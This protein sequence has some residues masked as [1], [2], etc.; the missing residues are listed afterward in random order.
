MSWRNT[1]V[2]LAVAVLLGAGI[3]LSNRRESEQQEAE[4]QAK[5]LFGAL[6]AGQVEW[7]ALTT[8]DGREARLARQEGAWRMTGP[9]DFPAD[10]TA[11][12]AIAGALARLTSE[13][14]I[15]DPEPPAVYGLGEGVRIVRFAAKGQEHELRLGKKTPVGSSHYAATGAGEG[16]PVYTVAAFATT[17]FDKALDDLRERRPLR[18]ER[19]AVTRIEADWTGGRAVVEKQDGRW[20]LVEPFAGEADEDTIETLLSDLAFLRAAGFVDEPPPPAE[21]G[22]DAPEYRVV[23]IGTAAEGKPAPRWELAIGSVIEPN[24]R[25]GKAAEPALYKIPVDRFEKLPKKVEAFRFKQL[26]QFVASD[27]ERFELIFPDLAAARQGASEVVTITGTRTDEGWE[28]TPE[29]MAAGLAARMVAELSRLDAAGIAADEV[30]PQE[31]AGLGLSP[32][33]ATIRVYGK[34]EVPE[35]TAGADEGAAALLADLQ[36]GV[37]DGDRIIA[38][39]ADRPTIFRLDAAKAED[40]PVSLEAFR[41]RFVS[42]EAPAEETESPPGVP[43]A[44]APAAGAA[45]PAEA[46]APAEGAAPPGGP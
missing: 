4:E 1:L 15:E 41:N 19:E 3:W 25:A 11:A 34:P 35:G 2:L 32:P 36:L 38:R 17:A 30:G 10:P 43:A 40:V 39:R 22:L 12:D 24:A 33:H 27:A 6:E 42:K 16:A 31:L 28:T 5:R 14:V 20:K 29:P 7:V 9:V 26:S 37:Q 13:A 44:D 8:S 23:L 46:P 45:P 18:F 21:V